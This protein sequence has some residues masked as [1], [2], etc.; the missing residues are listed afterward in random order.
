MSNDGNTSDSNTSRDRALANWDKHT[1]PATPCSVQTIAQRTA[2][3]KDIPSSPRAFA[4]TYLPGHERRLYSVI[5][6]GVTDDPNFKPAIAAAENFHVDYITAGQGKGAAL[7]AHDSEE[8]FVASRGR[9]EVYWL[10][11]QVGQAEPIRCSVVLDEC[12][13]VSVPPF[14]MRGFKSLDGER[15]L[16]LSIL[17][18]KHPNRVKWHSSVAQAAQAV[19]VGFDDHGNALRID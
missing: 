13:V 7:H 2:R 1:A 15:G 6:L 17:G 4:D 8:V 14:V 16:L 11:A 5:G 10:D 19:N 18:G 12:D 3:F 9:W